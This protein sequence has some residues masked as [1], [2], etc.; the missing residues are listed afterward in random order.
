MARSI[1]VLSVGS[2]G[3]GLLQK[4]TGLFNL[5]ILCLHMH[6]HVAVLN[7]NGTNYYR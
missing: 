4:S 3:N 2:F 5:M 6:A 7:D 1:A